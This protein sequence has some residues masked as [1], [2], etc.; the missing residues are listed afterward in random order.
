MKLAKEFAAA[1]PSKKPSDKL[2]MSLSK[3]ESPRSKFLQKPGNKPEPG[4]TITFMPAMKK[5]PK[6]KGEKPL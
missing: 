2:S 5:R 6:Q 4:D 3:R 1:E